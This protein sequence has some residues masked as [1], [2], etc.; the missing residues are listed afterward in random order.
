[1]LTENRE[2][3]SLLSRG[4]YR[5]YGLDRTR[6]PSRGA[7][8]DMRNISSAEFPCAAPAP[9]RVAA[10][11]T[12]NDIQAAAAPDGLV[13]GSVDGLTGVMGGAFYYNG[14]SR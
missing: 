13:S 5:F 6:R 14:V 8:E 9:S 11:T 10:V 12:A 1:M 7:V 4:T 2:N 3:D